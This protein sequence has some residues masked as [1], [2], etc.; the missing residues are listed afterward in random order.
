MGWRVVPNR[1]SRRNQRKTSENQGSLAQWAGV[2][3]RMALDRHGLKMLLASGRFLCFD[4][5]ELSMG[6]MAR[7][8][9]E[10]HRANLLFDERVLN[11]GIFFKEVQ[12]TEDGEVV[13]STRVYFPFIADEAELGGQSTVA[14][15]DRITKTL[16]RQ[17]RFQ[18]GGTLSSHDQHTLDLLHMIPTFDPFLLLSR[19]GELESERPVDQAYFDISQ[20]DWQRI[21]RPVMEKISRLVRKA[22]GGGGADLLQ[23]AASI[24]EAQQEAQK[25]MTASVIDAIWQGDSSEGTRQLIRGFKLDEAR[26][27][28]FLFAWKGVSYYEYQYNT[29]VRDL[30]AF[31]QWLGDNHLSLPADASMLQDSQLE[32][33][34][35]RRDMARKLVRRSYRA[36]QTVLK[37]YNDSFDALVNNENPKPFKDFLE[38]APQAFMMIGIAIGVLAHSAVAW[39]E[40][41]KAGTKRVKSMHIEPFY[42]FVIAVNGQDFMTVAEQH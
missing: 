28:E 9:H 26:T 34:K 36:I 21:R 8:Q 4:V 10:P 37:E 20:S 24:N 6:V 39:S 30:Q 7:H 5:R 1:A 17:G 33:L 12:D 15:P 32:R 41:T 25:L 13:V 3:G 42:D 11:E 2:F 19:R 38:R 31:F 14:T 40:L 16:E 29:R 18:R 23:A 35:F 27:S 22:S